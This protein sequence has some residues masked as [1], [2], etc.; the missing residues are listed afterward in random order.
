MRLHASRLHALG[1]AGLLITTCPAFAARQGDEIA[2][3]WFQD[4]LSAGASVA[5]YGDL[6]QD[7]TTTIIDNVEVRYPFHFKLGEKAEF[8]GQIDFNSKKLT[9]EGLTETD[10]TFS[11]DRITAADGTTILFDATL[12]EQKTAHSDSSDAGNTPAAEHGASANGSGKADEKQALEPKADNDDVAK[13][14]AQPPEENSVHIKEVFDG[15]EIAGTEWPRF[16]R[17]EISPEHRV[18]DSVRYA[19]MYLN[20]IRVDSAAVRQLSVE[21]TLPDNGVAKAS[22]QNLSA[23][24]VVGG[25]MASEEIE[26]YKSEQRIPDNNGQL[27][28]VLTSID[29]MTMR[30]FDIRPFLRA[31][32]P[33]LYGEDVGEIV[34]G[35]LSVGG[36]AVEIP[37]EN[38]NVAIDEISSKGAGIA[39]KGSNFLVE[40]DRLA[41][42]EQ[43]D[44]EQTLRAFFEFLSGYSLANTKLSG[45]Q[46]NVKGE[47]VGQ[48]DN[49][50]IADLD[51]EG[52][53][54]FLVEGAGAVN[55]ANA[56]QFGLSRLL[57][58]DLTFPT[59][60]ALFAL[61]NARE[62]GDVQA[63]MD[64]I[65]TIG[66]V[67]V[68]DMLMSGPGRPGSFSLANYRLLLD[69][70]VGPIPTD[71]SSTI[72]GLNFPVSFVSSPK[73]RAI[74]SALG[75][76]TIK[77]DQNLR[78]HWN[79]ETQDLELEQAHV[80]LENGGT[81]TVKLALGG[82][83]RFVFE[84]P[85]RAQ[86]AI[87]TLSVKGG[88]I[89]IEDAP[90]ITR[91]IE[92]QAKQANVSEAEIRAATIAQIRDS[93][94]PLA[95]TAF[96]ED[97]A[98]AA[99]RFM[100]DPKRIEIQLKPENPVPVAQLLGMAATAPQ[101]IPDVLKASASAE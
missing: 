21:Q 43:E 74:L 69:K 52:L 96:A 8:S 2:A 76:E 92:M 58:A 48:I 7:G 46:V 57:L 81:A 53:G 17:P 5:Q 42:G 13:A 94:G 6:R 15:Y 28:T 78:L 39:A 54:T 44:Q 27:Q 70:Y 40:A 93:L 82:V 65:P 20:G 14:G 49:L 26:S 95:D 80:A 85:K 33:T 72:S 18:S 23:R 35:E 30:D 99:D 73:S 98:K 41:S 38:V 37:D 55:P 67:E 34:L 100:Q 64:A 79:G 1:L 47:R 97:L 29:T 11:A 25:R 91:M 31:I 84:N 83:P 4:L 45:L 16:E 22:Y 86:E 89:V 101:T 63:M 66:R 36:I 32:D 61:K 68:D 12:P 62:T 51:D 60:D 56:S 90:A 77:V 3:G 24:G 10:K 19:A 9:F 87:A 50:E 75:F 59:R 71:I 88:S